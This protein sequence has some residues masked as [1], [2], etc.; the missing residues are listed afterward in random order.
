MRSHKIRGSGDEN[1]FAILT[2]VKW[3]CSSFYHLSMC[4]QNGGQRFCIGSNFVENVRGFS[5]EAP[6]PSC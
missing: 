3:I 6:Q 4:N 1:G 2:K 5:V